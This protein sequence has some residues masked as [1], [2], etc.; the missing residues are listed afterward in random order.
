MEQPTRRPRRW[1]EARRAAAIELAHVHEHAMRS[2]LLLRLLLLLS[3]VRLLLLLLS[4]SAVV[5]RSILALWQRFTVGHRLLLLLQLLLLL[6]I[7]WRNAPGTGKSRGE[8][9]VD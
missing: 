4:L 6:L 8:R 2:L 1:K 9:T 7:R 3:V 5:R